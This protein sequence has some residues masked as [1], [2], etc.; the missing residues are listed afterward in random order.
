MQFV[1]SASLAL[2]SLALRL[3]RQKIGSFKAHGVD[4]C[5]SLGGNEF[6]GPLT[7]L[8]IAKDLKGSWVCEMK[9]LK[10]LTIGIPMNNL[11]KTT[12]LR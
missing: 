4:I 9:N 6:M 12:C 5:F 7:M 2:W 1:A 8:P 11:S 3:S 10:Q